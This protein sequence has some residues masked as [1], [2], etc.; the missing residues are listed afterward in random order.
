MEYAAIRHF[1]DKRYCYAI[2]KGRFLIRLETKKGDAEKVIL[3]VQDKYLRI[4]HVDTRR[5]YA[6]K[7]AYS[8]NYIDYYEVMI[9]IDVV[10]LR[11]FFEIKDVSGKKVYYGNHN[12]Y[13]ESIT[14][15]DRMFDCPQSPREEEIFEMP[16]WARNKVVYQIF[17]SRFASD[18][19]IPEEIWYQAPIDHKADL[20]GSLRGIINHLDYI[21]EM[22]IDIIYMTPI[23]S[24]NS[25]HKY[26]IDD[27]YNIDPSFGTKEDLKELVDKAHKL[28]MYVILDGVFNHTAIDFFAFRDIRE[29]KEQSK[30]LNWY[31]IKDFPL[32]IE[33]GK[34]PNYKTF[35]Y[36]AFMPKLNLQNKETADYIINVASYWIKEC[37]IDGWRLDVADEVN[38]AF[39]KRFRRE[40]K[41]VKKDVMIIGEIWHF[42]SD[43]LE[44][45][46]WDSIMNYQFYYAVFDLV[47]LE[48]LTASSFVGNLNFM[49]GS[50]HKELEGFLWNFIDSHD[51]ARFLYSVGHDIKRLKLAAALQLL[52]PGMPMIYYGDETALDGGPDPDCRR[53]ML[54]DESRQNAEIRDYYKNLIRIRHEYPVLTEGIIVEQYVEDVTGVIYTERILKNQSIVLIFHIQKGIVELPDL[55]GMK[56]LVN[57]RDFSGSMGDYETVVLVG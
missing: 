5:E 42:A 1:A 17:P 47:V 16:D 21:K 36:A 12:F 6:M 11:Y 22:G 50:L 52:L 39:W 57:D 53:G 15:I 34:K 55:V 30:Y 7:I 38:H 13:D 48:K 25:S 37:D 26:N 23:F 49:R 54:W 27:Y 10:C 19:D 24:S 56:N 51:T 40:I 29:K 18:Q 31:Y 41:A 43:F 4:Q 8:D 28:G 35:S 14:D 46:E 3:H 9:D 45:D 33:W 2:A 32:V 44:G 20:K